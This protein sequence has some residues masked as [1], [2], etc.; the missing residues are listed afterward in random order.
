M[1][2]RVRETAVC[3]AP[4]PVLPRRC[5][6]ELGWIGAIMY[7]AGALFEPTAGVIKAGQPVSVWRRCEGLLIHDRASGA[8]TTRG[9]VGAIELGTPA[10][11]RAGALACVDG[12]ARYERGVRDVIELIRAGDIFQANL[13]HRLQAGFAG[14]ARTLLAHMLDVSGAWHGA[15]LEWDDADRHAVA[16]ASPELF[17]KLDRHGLVTTRPMK[18]TSLAM[19][20]TLEAS[21]KDQAELNMIVDLMRNDLGRVCR[22]GSVR[23]EEARAIET[24]G[25]G[26]GALH[27]GVATVTGRLREGLGL[28]ELIGATFP[29]GSITGAP[30]IRAMQI[31]RELEGF[32]RGAFCGGI[33]F[34]G[35]DGTAQLGIG[36]RTASIEGTA[37]ANG[38]DAFDEATLTYPVGAGVVVDSDP[39]SEWE[40]TMNKS[41]VLRDAVARLGA[42]R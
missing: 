2:A 25:I 3:R 34:I 28:H 17:L 20:R 6:G 30:K 22:C 31:I 19:D 13:A 29:G 8:W 12:R 42:G 36:I 1:L 37:S 15:Y 21:V 10:S 23:V 41:R 40:E 11:A 7:E 16:S 4:G 27:Q 35:D 39:A 32:R 5:Q 24:H 18:G 26:P 38:L 33:G 9:D 14:S